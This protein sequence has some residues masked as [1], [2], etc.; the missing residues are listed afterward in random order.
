MTEEKEKKG[1][2]QE[3]FIKR[4]KERGGFFDRLTCILKKK[5][6]ATSPSKSIIKVGGRKALLNV[7]FFLVSLFK[8]KRE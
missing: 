2:L 7:F 5:V 6:V 8:Q 3:F 4:G 1:I